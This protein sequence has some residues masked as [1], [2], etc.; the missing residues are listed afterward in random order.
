MENPKSQKNLHVDPY[1][2]A[3]EQSNDPYFGAFKTPHWIGLQDGWTPLQ[4]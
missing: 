3:S 4:V 1:E 2:S